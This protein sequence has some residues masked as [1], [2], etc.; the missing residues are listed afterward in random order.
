M[1]IGWRSHWLWF[2]ILLTAVSIADYI[3]HITRPASEFAERWPQWLAFSGASHLTF[4]AVAFGS[5][6]L[7]RR[8]AVPAVLADCLGVAAAVVVHLTLSGPLWGRVFWPQA[9]LEFAGLMVPVAA[10]VGLYLAYR[11]L[12]RLVLA[13]IDRFTAKSRSTPST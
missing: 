12:F 2:A 5:A 11:G 7:L 1:T 3:D 10:A 4:L 8:V 9:R 13:A 6:A